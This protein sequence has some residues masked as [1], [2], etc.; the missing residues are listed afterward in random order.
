MRECRAI[1]EPPWPLGIRRESGVPNDVN[2]VADGRR[3]VKSD[4]EIGASV[5]VLELREA[6]QVDPRRER[7]LEAARELCCGEAAGREPRH[8]CR[9]ARGEDEVTASA[10]R[11]APLDGAATAVVEL[12][13]TQDGT[14]APRPSRRSL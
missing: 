14:G 9:I 6:E 2:V 10:I 4:V 3:P 1:G 12:A 13:G 8:R 5:F 11:A 7:V